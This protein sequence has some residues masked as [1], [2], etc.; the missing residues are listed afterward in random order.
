MS[1][2]RIAVAV[3]DEALDRVAEVALACR[4]LGFRADSTLVGVGVF[5]GWIEF[6]AI[7]ALRALPGVAAVEI[8]RAPRIHRPGPLTKGPRDSGVG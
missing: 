5:T 3:A 2:V 7:E 8:E 4:A 1:H 6:N